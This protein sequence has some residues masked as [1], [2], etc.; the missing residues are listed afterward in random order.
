MNGEVFSE[1]LEHFIKFTKSTLEK[2]VLLILDG[3]KSH[4]HSIKA[5]QRASDCGVMMI[6]LP[7]H[8][9]HRLQPLDL[10]FFKPLKTYYYQ[11]VSKWLRNHPGRAVTQYQISQLF[12]FAYG[13]AA[14]CQHCF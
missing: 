9:S 10:C 14:S 4:T 5:L 2:K 8:T 11:E 3:H 7:P 13:K 1:W 6:S 12:G